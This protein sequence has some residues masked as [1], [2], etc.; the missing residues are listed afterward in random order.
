MC[1]D[2]E[3]AASKFGPLDL[4]TIPSY[5]IKLCLL[6]VLCS[7][8]DIHLRYDLYLPSQFPPPIS[9]V[10]NL[11]LSN[12]GEDGR[13]KTKTLEIVAWFLVLCACTT[14]STVFTMEDE[15]T[16]GY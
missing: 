14:E 15:K 2:V 6:H 9:P 8:P 10:S 16:L 5:Q 13:A 3:D 1:L 11:F 7:F 12:V 4:F